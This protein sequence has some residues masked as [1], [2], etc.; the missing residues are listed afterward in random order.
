MILL[1]LPTLRSALWTMYL[2]N[3]RKLRHLYPNRSWLTNGD[4]M[5][6]LTFDDGPHPATTP[7]LLAI[8]GRYDV[9]ATFF[10]LGSQI[11]QYPDLYA[12][13]INQGHN[14]GNHTFDHVD[15]WSTSL[16]AYIDNVERCHS[17]CDS[18]L[19]RPP[20]GRITKKQERSL[21]K[22]GYKIVM[23]S[24]MPGDW[25]DN[26]SLVTLKHRL[27]NRQP[28]DIIVLHD[29]GKQQTVELVEW[30][31]SDNALRSNAEQIEG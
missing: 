31:L 21:L 22:L 20:Y 23:W 12:E 7:E 13:I 27:D 1:I 29:Q 16:D 24:R 25:E 6:H 30:L 4:R 26:V 2:V 10:C 9:H 19:F 17:V 5:L 3:T 11:E 14:V 28:D 8:L 18:H 15:G